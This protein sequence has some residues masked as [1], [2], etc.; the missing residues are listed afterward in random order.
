[1]SQENNRQMLAQ[2]KLAYLTDRL[3]KGFEELTQH[4]SDLQELEMICT[5]LSNEE[6]LTI[7]CQ[8]WLDHLLIHS[9]RFL[10]ELKDFH[11]LRNSFDD[12]YQL[13][14][15]QHALKVVPLQHLTFLQK[16]FHKK[17]RHLLNAN[18]LS[19]EYINEIKRILPPIN[20]SKQTLDLYPN[21]QF[22]K[23]LSDYFKS[24]RFFSQEMCENILTKINNAKS[25]ASSSVVVAEHDRY[26]KSLVGHFEA[27]FKSNLN[28]RKRKRTTDSADSSASSNGRHSSGGAEAKVNSGKSSGGGSSSHNLYTSH[29][30][31]YVNDRH[32][33]FIQ[34]ARSLVSP[35]QKFAQQQ[36]QQQHRTSNNN[37]NN[38]NDMP[39]PSSKRVHF[40]SQVQSKNDSSD[41]LFPSINYS[42]NEEK[43]QS[44]YDMLYL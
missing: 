13:L 42:F 27:T 31:K 34:L 19:K 24:E 17:A 5:S 12:C 22:H 28:S 25:N 36:Q 2:L 43:D 29:M 41:D 8:I 18:I 30:E 38:N 39:I 37:N 23:E 44:Y 33:K 35:S 40:N 26:E 1:M 9:V 15:S 4:P 7:K 3:L 20:Q 10:R 11:R 6:S 21:D 32:Q 14:S 16:C